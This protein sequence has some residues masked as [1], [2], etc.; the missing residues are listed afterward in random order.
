MGLYEIML[1]S[2]ELRKL[3]TPTTDLA[4]VREQAYARGHEAPAHPAR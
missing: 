3:V 1:M 4:R 2:P